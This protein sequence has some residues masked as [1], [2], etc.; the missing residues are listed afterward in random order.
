MDLQI[1]RHVMVRV[2]TPVEAVKA[3]GTADYAMEVANLNAGNVMVLEL[4]SGLVAT[5][6]EMVNVQNAEVLD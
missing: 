6:M 1:V 4:G 2:N 3:P 5:V